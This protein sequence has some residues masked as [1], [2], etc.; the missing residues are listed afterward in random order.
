MALLSIDSVAE[1]P[2][3]SVYRGKQRRP[4]DRLELRLVTLEFG[5]GPS[6]LTIVSAG[7]IDNI[8]VQRETCCI[9][10]PLKRLQRLD[11]VEPRQVVVEIHRNGLPPRRVLHDPHFPAEYSLTRVLFP[12]AIEQLS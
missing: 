2:K 3:E 11:A 5:H 9:L 4:D 8:V 7:E 1:Q 10:R 12:E 6:K